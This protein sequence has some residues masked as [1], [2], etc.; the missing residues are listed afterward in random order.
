MLTI[1]PLTNT[2]LK[3]LL[4]PKTTLYLI[5]FTVG[6]RKLNSVVKKTVTRKITIIKN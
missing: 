5:P 4:N 3:Y 6:T 1:I 2:Y